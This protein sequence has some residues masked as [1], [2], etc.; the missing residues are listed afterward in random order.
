MTTQ[1]KTQCPHCQTKLVAKESLVGK[2]V[3]CRSCRQEFV[4]TFDSAPEA[5]PAS[6]SDVSPGLA[7]TLDAVH[8]SSLDGLRPAASPQPVKR[9]EPSTAKIGRFEVLTVLGQ[10]A[11]GRVY[12]ARDP[13]LDRFV[14]LK[15][16]TFGPQ[17]KPKIQR[18]LT[19]AKSAAKLHHP[20]IVPT[21]ECVQADGKYFI[22]AQFVAGQPLSKR[23]KDNPP[24][25]RQAAEWVRQLAGGLAYA[26]GQGIVHRDIKPDNIMLSEDGIPQIM[27]FGLAKRVNEDAGM[28]TDGSVLGTPVYMPPEQARGDMSK[29]GPHSDQ[30]SLGVVLYELLTGKR[31]FEG[32]VH[33]VLAAVL[34]EEPAAPRKVRAEIPKDLE[35]IC[36]KAMSKDVE[37]RYETTAAFAGDVERWL[38][39]DS[40]FARPISSLERFQRWYRRE[41]VTSGLAV[42]VVALA[43]IGF[44]GISLALWHANRNAALAESRRIKAEETAQELEKTANDLAQQKKL[45]EGN[46]EIAN[47]KTA[48]AELARNDALGKKKEAEVALANLEVEVG[49]RK[50]AE[51]ATV[52]VEKKAISLEQTTAKLAAENVFTFYA[53]RIAKVNS[54]IQG[55]NL[56]LAKSLLEECI[57]AQRGW[58]WRFL[59]AQARNSF[60]VSQFVVSQSKHTEGK[61]VQLLTALSENFTSRN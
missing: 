21:Y 13:Q 9:A 14:A 43:L 41:P 39:G 47:E 1:Q 17:D 49:K 55:K 3:R 11:F 12:K 6:G 38:R 27:D 37:R 35:A 53:D 48:E 56:S 15:V 57:E 58:E 50:K 40:I 7:E 60:G 59:M 28:T 44:T 18:F 33:A 24:D 20:N 52:T 5:K 32:P 45:A 34:S 36:Q 25:F 22:A 2:R 23:L 51:E 54:E 61:S 10:G 16:P 19:E 4:L 29:V 26:H 8:D 42:A 31:P 46:L 30:Y